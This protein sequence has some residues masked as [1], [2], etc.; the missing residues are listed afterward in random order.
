MHIN[1]YFCSPD[2]ETVNSPEMHLL[3]AFNIKHL[4][5]PEIFYISWIAGKTANFG[6]PDPLL[7]FDPGFLCINSRI[8]ENFNVWKIVE[9]AIVTDIVHRRSMN[10]KRSFKE[11]SVS[12]TLLKVHLFRTKVL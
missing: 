6:G 3:L 9:F 11:S 12:R 5:K 8:N 4:K 10:E 2:Y 7:F 1:A